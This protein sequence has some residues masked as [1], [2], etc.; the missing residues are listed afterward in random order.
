M[1]TTFLLS[2]LAALALAF[3]CLPAVPTDGDAVTLDSLQKA[4]WVKG[5]AIKSWEPGKVYLLECWATWCGP[6][7]ASIPHINGL[8][9]KYKDK[10][11][12]V[13]GVNVYEDGKD[14]V[15]AF[16]KKKGAGMSYP[17]VYTGKGSDFE[18][19]WMRK[20]EM[21]LP[22]PQIWVVKDGKLLSRV[23]SSMLTEEV[24][25]GL[26]KGGDAQDAAM[27]KISDVQE[28]AK[29]K[30]KA[31]KPETLPPASTLTP[32]GPPQPDGQ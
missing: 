8:Y 31:A 18:M 20:G 5:D 29:A 14:A 25:E 9:E 28:E 19:T 24:I 21:S 1:K 16:V 17:S 26:L 10:G 3:P 27:K 4:E 30:A 2:A 6:C 13:I 15:A 12:R 11:L 32:V 7:V 23:V 22:I